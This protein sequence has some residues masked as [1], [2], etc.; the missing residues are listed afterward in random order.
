MSGHEGWPTEEPSPSEIERIADA[1]ARFEEAWRRG[2]RPRIEDSLAEVG[3]DAGSLL[4]RLLPLELSFRLG[5][6]ESPEPEEYRSRFPAS[7][8]VVDAA[9]AEQTTAADASSPRRPAG[10]ATAANLLVGILALQN[11]FIDHVALIGAIQAWAADK[12]RNLGASLVAAG[13]LDER[14]LGLLRAMAEEHRRRHGDDL[15]RS[16]AAFG[17]LTPVFRAVGGMGDADVTSSLMTEPPS[18]VVADEATLGHGE[19]ERGAGG[20]PG[21]SS[22]ASRFQVLS[23]HNAGM[24]GQVFIALDR[25]LNRNVALKEIQDRHASHPVSREQFVL[26]GMV[27]GALEHPGIVPVYSLGTRA[28]GTPFYAMRFIQG[29]SLREKLRQFHNADEAKG[30]PPGEEPPTLPRLLRHFV[31]ACNAMAYAHSRGVI[32]RDLKPEH[33]LLGPFGET[34]VVDWGLAMPILGGSDHPSNPASSLQLPAGRESALMQDGV[35]VGTLP[36]MSPEQAEGRQSELDRRSDVYALGAILFAVLTGRAPVVGGDFATVLEKARRGDFPRPREI[37]RDAPPA[38]EAIC[39]KAMSRDPA[40]RYDTA[41]DLARDVERWLDDEPTTAYAEPWGVRAGRW[42]RRHRTAA[43]AAAAVLGCS[44]VGLVALNVQAV[45]ANATIARERDAVRAARNEAEQNLRATVAVLDRILIPIASAGTDPKLTASIDLRKRIAAEAAE[46]LDL[47]QDRRPGD[48]EVRFLG[49][50]AS[51]ELATIQRVLGDPTRETY[52][53]SI[54]LIRAALELNPEQRRYRDVLAETLQDAA[55]AHIMEGR[56]A[57]AESLYREALEVVADLRRRHPDSQPYRRTEARVSNTVANQRLAEGDFVEAARLAASA[58]AIMIE[59]ADSLVP[60]PTDGLEAVLYQD[61]L[62]EALL[63]MGREGDSAAAFDQVIRRVDGLLEGAPRDQ[64]LRFLKASALMK[65]ARA[66]LSDPDRALADASAA[67]DAFDALARE[68]E[69]IVPYREALAQALLV[70]STVH[71]AQGRPDDARRDLERALQATEP[72]LAADG[73]RPAYASLIGRA[74]G[75]LGR[76]DLQRGDADA[77]GP[78]LRRAAALLE[79]A[80]K[81]N[82]RSPADR[83]AAEEAAAL[84]KTS[85][86]PP[87]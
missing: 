15:A 11:G 26:E 81:A 39:L 71:E 55:T 18:T 24:L 36:Y 13:H 3:P 51:R 47:L 72:L 84:L 32:H 30:G 43:A 17:S 9:F 22:S 2:E 57:D 66:R 65:R 82:P 5:A 64:N 41:S 6:G 42:L 35:V 38:L 69:A 68:F 16:L 25:E 77:A 45:R 4:E 53:R 76:L 56:P 74:L 19:G 10:P 86:E 54:G 8:G 75:R 31:N 80:L 48:P 52:S 28:D 20:P 67:V 78:R 83:K 14:Q 23:F 61:T 58:S 62:G 33:I 21:S 70:R 34:L 63:E 46:F 87:R 44:L 29:P 40:G 50:L 27:T 59:L 60:G 79:K 12:S 1:C 49:A 73:D 85:Q 37:A 7:R